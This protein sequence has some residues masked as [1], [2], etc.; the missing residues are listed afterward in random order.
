MSPSAPRTALVVGQGGI[1]IPNSEIVERIKRIHPAL[2]LRFSD[3]IGGLGWAI[4]WEWQENDRRRQ[5]I[6][7][8]RTDPNMAYDIVGYLPMGCSLNEAPAYIERSLKQYPREEVSGLVSRM[9]HWNNVERP[10]EVVA[11]LTAK[12][13]ED[14]ARDQRAPVGQIISVPSGKVKSKRSKS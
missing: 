7:D 9:S 2:N 1:P 10:K 12:T 11:E 5:W 6:Q 14:Y 4:T 3:G 13:M 8:G